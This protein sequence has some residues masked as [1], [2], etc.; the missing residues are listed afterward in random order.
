ME[1]LISDINLSFQIN[2]GHASLPMQTGTVDLIGFVQRLIADVANDPRAAAYPLS[3]D[4]E[5][6]RLELLAD[7]KLLYRALQN[8]LLNAVIHNPEGTNIHVTIRKDG[9]GFAE[10]T[11]SDDGQGMDEHMLNHLFHKYYRGAAAGSPMRG[12]GLGL[13]IV[14]SLILAHGGTLTA[15]SEVSKGSSFHIRL[16]V[17]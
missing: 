16:P 7:E 8:V 13:S 10:I 14:K 3:M 6:Q 5:E 15:E 9:H 1:E 11:V 2:H 17:L 4:S 12:L